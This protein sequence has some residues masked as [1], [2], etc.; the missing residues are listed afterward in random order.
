MS[1]AY[2]SMIILSDVSIDILARNKWSLLIYLLVIETNKI[3]K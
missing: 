2:D 3:N 1:F